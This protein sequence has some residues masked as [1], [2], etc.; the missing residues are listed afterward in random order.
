MRLIWTAIVVGVVAVG[1]TSLLRPVV[2]MLVTLGLCV[3]LLLFYLH[4]SD[5]EVDHVIGT[6]EAELIDELQQARIENQQARAELERE[7]SWS[8]GI[9]AAAERA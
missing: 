1:V 9:V 5:E 2:P 8:S 6:H 4:W 7:R 3:G